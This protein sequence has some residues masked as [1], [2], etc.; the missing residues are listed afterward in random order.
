MQ[1][2][3]GLDP[4]NIQPET[5][6]YLSFPSPMSFIHRI[7][8]IW[9]RTCSISHVVINPERVNMMRA[10]QRRGVSLT[11]LCVSWVQYG[12]LWDN[13]NVI[14]HQTICKHTQGHV[15]ADCPLHVS[16][17]VQNIC[18]EQFCT[19]SHGNQTAAAFF[20]LWAERSC[21]VPFCF[22]AFRFVLFILQNISSSKNYTWLYWQ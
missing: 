16:R 6:N 19:C 2:C 22:H 21:W 11:F 14:R 1:L 5:I 15:T 9:L 20:R 8:I 7:R 3:P 13:V 17:V 12:L 10:I 18:A 4:L